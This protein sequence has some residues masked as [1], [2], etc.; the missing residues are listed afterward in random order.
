MARRS[1]TRISV[2]VNDPG[3]RPRKCS[4]RRVGAVT[5]RAA[6]RLDLAELLAAVENAPP[7]AAADVLGAWLADAIGATAVSFLVVDF[8]GRALIRLGHAGASAAMRTQGRETAERVALAD[9]PHGLSLR[10]QT[11]EVEEADGETRMFA[12]VTNRGEAIGVLELQPP[13]AAGRADACRR[14]ARGARA[15]LHRHRQPP[16]H[17]PLRVGPAVGPPL[18][19]GGDPASPAPRRVH[20]RGRAVHARGLARARGRDRRR[21]LRLRDG[22]RHAAPLDVGCQGPRGRRVG[23]GDPARRRAAQRAASRGRVGGAGAPRERGARRVRG[24]DR[25]RDGAGRAHR[26]A[27]AGRRRSSTPATS[28]RCAC[29]TGASS[30]WSCSPT[31]RSGSCASTPTRC[32]TCR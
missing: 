8:S 24:M 12:P 10:H 4:R 20:V 13:G 27:H 21:Q 22:A 11:V 29:A 17:R 14:R 25:L 6:G 2:A 5:D 3:S 23:A 26:P 30:P 16:L 1:G 31:R 9:S 32:R 18:A 28:L 19:R 15:R 7:V